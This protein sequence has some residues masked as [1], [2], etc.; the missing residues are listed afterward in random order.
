MRARP[1]FASD[2]PH[3]I[4][5]DDCFAYQSETNTF[6]I[7][8]TALLTNLSKETLLGRVNDEGWWLSSPTLSHEEVRNLSLSKLEP[9]KA[10]T[11]SMNADTLVANSISITDVQIIENLPSNWVSLYGSKKDH[12]AYH[13]IRVANNLGLHGRNEWS[14]EERVIYTLLQ[15]FNY[16]GAK[17]LQSHRVPFIFGKH[18]TPLVGCNDYGVFNKPMRD[19]YS[20]VNNAQLAHFIQYEERLFS[21]DD[22]RRVIS[23]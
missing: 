11:V 18:D 2:P 5:H 23:Q 1:S 21:A 13:A 7:S 16:V 12:D 3:A 15:M 19:R 6:F 4:R 20:F 22:L 8:A 10:I 14:K 17:Y 9:R